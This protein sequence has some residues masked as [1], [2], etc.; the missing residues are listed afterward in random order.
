[1]TQRIQRHPLL[2]L[3]DSPDANT[4]TDRRDTS[5]VP[6][7]ALF[8]MNNFFVREQAEGLARRLLA[9]SADSTQ[10]IELAHKLA[11]CNEAGPNEVESETRYVEAYQKEL[12]R[13][14]ICNQQQELEAWTSYA[15][16]LLCA[17]EFAYV[18]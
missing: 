12:G 6:Q 8:L 7:Q 15:R 13:L 3:F 11:W 5:I 14:G 1:M 9:A 2:S 4:T 18:D 16:V 17:N 10:R